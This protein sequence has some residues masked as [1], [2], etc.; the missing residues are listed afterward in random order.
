MAKKIKLIVFDADKFGI[1]L[2]KII[3]ESNVIL[4]G[5]GIPSDVLREISKTALNDNQ[6]AK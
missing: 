5:K 2:I 4:I 3:N 1:D 6:F